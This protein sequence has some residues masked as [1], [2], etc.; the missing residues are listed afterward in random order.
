MT[1]FNYQTLIQFKQARFGS[2]IITFDDLIKERNFVYGNKEYHVWIARKEK[3]DY[4]IL[5]EDIKN[6]P[7]KIQKT[8][9][10]KD[11]KAIYHF[12]A[13]CN[14]IGFSPK[15]YFDFRA[16]TD[17]FCEIMHT[18]KPHQRLKWI[19]ALTSLLQRINVRKCGNTELGKDSTYII[20]NHLTNKVSV[21]DKPKTSAKMEYGL[22]NDVLMVNE[23]V[24]NKEEERHEMNDYLLSI[25]SLNPTYQKKTRSSAGTKETYD[26]AKFSL[27]VCYNTLQEIAEK[28]KVNYFD[29]AFGLNV[30]RRFLPLKFNGRIDIKQFTQALNYNEDVDR[31]LLEL[32]R[33]IEWYR[34]NWQTEKKDWLIQV[35]MLGERWELMFGRI[36]DGII[37]YSNTEDEARQMGNMLLEC[38]NGYTR[39]LS[40]NSL[41]KDYKPESVKV[42]TPA[43]EQLHPEILDFSELKPNNTLKYEDFKLSVLGML[44]DGRLLAIDEV[45]QT[46]RHIDEMAIECAIQKLKAESEVFEPKAG[47]LRKL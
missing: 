42:N 17:K 4:L 41:I 13:E 34:Q 25:G 39:M 37:L 43:D 36:M 10:I 12:V 20:L 40:N 2:N 9:I 24:P 46:Y 32:A 31:Q 35:P 14:R 27:V 23:L 18:N 5:N 1:I 7:I 45:V 30:L 19:I 21:F 15:R 29:Y 22:L 38:H 6:L 26:M 11:D 28:D 16:L 44:D 8:E 47:F 33:T 3:K